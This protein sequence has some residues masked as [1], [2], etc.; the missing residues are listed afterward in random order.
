MISENM[1]YKYMDDKGEKIRIIYIDEL[2]NEFAYVSIDIE[3]CM[4]KWEKLSK[5][6]AEIENN[7]LVKIIDP[8]LKS[9]DESKL[10]KL[11]KKKRD[12]YWDLISEV[13]EKRLLE[14]LKPKTRN[15][16]IQ[17]MST[18]SG[19][20]AITLKRLFSRFWQRGMTKNAL[21]NDYKNSGGKGKE[22]NLSDSKVG[23]PKKADYNG[24]I[25]TGINITED[26]KKQFEIAV[27]KYYRNSNKISLT[28]TYRFI[29]K[30]FFSDQYIE[31]GERKFSVWEKSRTPTYDQFYYWFKKLEDTK[32]DII[33]REGAK[34]FELTERP[35]LS[36]STIETDGPGTRFQVDAT[37]ADIY[38]VSSLDRNRIIGRPIVY[39]II[40]VFSRLVVG[41]YVGL[42]GPSWMGAMMALDNMLADKVEFCK[43]YDIN[44]TEEQWPAKH[45][46]DIIIADRGEFE[47]YSVENLINNLNV[48]IENT[49]P[50]RG[51]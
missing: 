2:K 25:I 13:H 24:D 26:I 50:Y 47:G 1:V 23:R 16:I 36:N 9:I 22:R 11:E 12:L 21:L 43:G 18:I 37:V 7:I 35:I 33:L 20:S 41:I 34:V 48:K 28:Q 8:Y 19:V 17:D 38:L 30:D 42:E 31:N 4:P 15:K 46:P 3:F 14:T 6:R 45:L 51:D 5:I 29:L 39:A 44:I 40:D 32:K 10:S 27:N 49:S